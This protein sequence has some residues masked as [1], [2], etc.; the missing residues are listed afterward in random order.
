MA[1]KLP[2]E[3]LGYYIELGAGRS[4]AAVADHFGVSKRAV[5]SRAIRDNWKQ[6]V[7]EIEAKAKVDAEKRAGE[8]LEAMNERHLRSLRAIQGKA[9]EALRTM[10]IETAMDAVRALDLGIRGERVV[11]GEPSERTAVGIEDIVKREYQSW[12]TTATDEQEAAA[13]D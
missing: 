1:A 4:Y 6:K 7:S 2:P 8:S 13:E 3:A 10:P 9:L 11:R 5:V 12:M